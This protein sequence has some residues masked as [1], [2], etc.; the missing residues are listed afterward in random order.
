MEDPHLQEVGLFQRI[1]HPTEGSIVNMDL[2]NKLSRGARSDFN[3]APKIGQHSVEI[4]REVGY[5]DSDIDA[6]VAGKVTVDGRIQK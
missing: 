3:P 1:E 4:L 6:L 2:P 5:S